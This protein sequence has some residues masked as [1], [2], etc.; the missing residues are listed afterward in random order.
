MTKSGFTMIE[1]IFVIIILGVLA[2]VVI[3]TLSAT[4]TDSMKVTLLDNL[5]TCILE[6]SAGYTAT[7]RESLN[8]P[9]CQ[10]VLKCFLIDRGEVLTD[11]KFIISTHNN[12]Q[13]DENLTYCRE[14]QEISDNKNTSRPLSSGGKIYTFGTN[15]LYY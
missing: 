14:A 15:G 6:I 10:S 2:S 4:R 9:S 5:R 13:I 12:S 7:G 8:S 1:I 11:G 3:P